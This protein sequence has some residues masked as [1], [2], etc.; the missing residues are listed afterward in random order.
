MLTKQQYSQ[1]LEELDNCNRPIF[2]F[3]DDTD[4]LCSFLLLYRYKREGKGVCVKSHPM[5]DSRFFKVVQEYEPDKIF[6][7]DLAVVQQ[8][9]VDEFRSIPMIWVD[10]H[11][12]LKL[13]HVKYFNPR[14]E[15]TEDGTCVAELCYNV[16]REQRPQDLWVAAVGIV[17][18]WQLSSVTKEF[19]GK[20][21]DLLPSSIDRPERALFDSP[22]S[23]LIKIMNFI[24]KG[25]TQEVMKCVKIFTRIES[26]YELLDGQTP[27]AKFILKRF[28]KIHALYEKLLH[29]AISKVSESDL[30]IVT[31]KEDKMSFTGELSN[32]LLYRY[33][34]KVILVAREKSGEM[35]CSLR[36]SPGLNLQKAIEK[37][38]DGVNGYGGGHEYA[39]GSCVKFEDFDKF[40]EQLKQVIR[41]VR[42]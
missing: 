42:K 33:P 32:E 5:V 8:E 39:C 15:N 27:Q 19:S 37:A 38:L 41:E 29:F 14:V 23:R 12:P 26:P 20:Y 34:K 30:L 16:V 13:P 3:H 17:G 31:Y 6:I 21:P 35:K 2:F 40:V 7:L 4:G 1:I 28:E 18:D 25:S 11:M 36:T 22:L 24:L 10:H 9:F